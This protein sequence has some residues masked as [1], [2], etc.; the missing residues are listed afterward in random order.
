M[1][2]CDICGHSSD[3]GSKCN[4]FVTKARKHF[5][6]KRV[7]VFRNMVDGEWVHVDDPGGTGLQI[8]QEIK[9]CADPKCIDSASVRQ[10]IA[11]RK[12]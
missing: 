9:V 10:S 3:L 2:K 4:K 7:G 6:P 12:T 5:F 8:V 1:F 11:L